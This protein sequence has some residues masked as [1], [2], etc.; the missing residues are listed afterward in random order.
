MIPPRVRLVEL[1]KKLKRVRSLK[2]LRYRVCKYLVC[3]GSDVREF[4]YKIN[5]HDWKGIIY[6][7]RNNLMGTIFS[8]FDNKV[9][10]IRGFPKIRYTHDSRVKD[11]ECVC[12]EKVDGTNIGIWAF[13]DGT[14]M[15]KTRMVER[16]D[17]GSKRRAGTWKSKFLR[18][19]LHEKIY[20]LAREDYLVFIE[21]YGY[22]NSGEFVKY[23]VEMAY[24][25]IGIVDLR[26]F[27]FLGRPEVEALCTKYE[28][29][30]VTV[31][32]KGTLTSKEVQRIEMD[33]D[34]EMTLDGMEGL[35]AKY[36]DMND[37][38][39]YFCKIKCEKIKE[40]CYKMSHS[41]IPA[42]LI[43]KAIKKAL[44]ENLGEKRIEVLLPFVLEELREEFDESLVEP[45]MSKIKSLIRYA[46]TPSNK[47]LKKV[48][49]EAMK[50]ISAQGIDVTDDKNKGKVLSSLHFRLGD[51]KGGT[52]YKIYLELLLEMKGKW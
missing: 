41:L 30:L 34:K 27:H 26:A 18:A 38:D 36:W 3:G 14:I 48:V 22:C 37:Y 9:L 52:L 35:V 45:S 19:P 47:E 12:E 29:P 31:Y 17:K 20:K 4:H 13:P 7:K 15:G 39:S 44:D 33:L 16:W 40:A 5:K 43:R 42:T 51:I 46:T 8:L 1:R 28:L 49:L 32:Y 25:V 6:L 24:K 2:T 11:Q 10:I 23:S 50:D 21:L